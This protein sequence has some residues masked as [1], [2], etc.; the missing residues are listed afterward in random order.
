MERVSVEQFRRSGCALVRP[1]VESEKVSLPEALGRVASHSLEATR[2]LPWFPRSTVDGYAL[3][4]EDQRRRLRVAGKVSAGHPSDR[5]LEGGEAFE[6][7]TG[8]PIPDGADAVALVEESDREGDYV[9]IRESLGV[10]A[11][12]SPIGEDF[13]LGQVLVRAG[14]P[15]TSVDIAALASQ[16]ISSVEVFR[17]PRVAI[18]STGDE[19]QP[20][21][22]PLGPGQVHDVNGTALEAL[23]RAA[24]CIPI[25]LGSL[26]DVYDLV[27]AGL[28]KAQDQ[29]DWDI[30][31]TS[32]GTGASI[33][34]FQGRDIETMHD[35]I[36]AVLAELGQL[37]HHGIRMVPGRPT[38]LGVLGDRPVFA[39][40]GWPYAVLIHF[41]VM[42]LP[43]LRKAAHLP[44]TRRWPREARL[45]APVQGTAGFT[46]IIQVKLA[47]EEGGL[48]A[49]PLLPPPPPS[50]SR[51]MTQM[52]D[53]DGYIIVEAADTLDTG[54]LV[55]VWI[56]P[57]RF[58]EDW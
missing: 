38:A 19:L 28:Q 40:P 56:D 48:S 17:R 54:H 6:I 49:T 45:T 20:L 35:L 55:T 31:I 25:R 24:G 13:A 8:A 42:V 36:P 7:T 4:A 10:G 21:D 37:V 50:A 46:R 3:R 30:L 15:L 22:Q 33:P 11:H 9:S 43:A 26:P 23:V 16:G 12:I 32:G 29:R 47:G 39:L 27:K 53:A 34:V 44:P 41:E 5:V 57:L 18:F 51:V 14:R 1:V 2:P 58:R 52:L